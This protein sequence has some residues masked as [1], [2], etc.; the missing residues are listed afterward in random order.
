MNAV[1]WKITQKRRKRKEKKRKY[2]TERN[3]EHINS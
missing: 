2:E 1:P 3:A